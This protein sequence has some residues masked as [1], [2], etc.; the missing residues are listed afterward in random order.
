MRILKL[1]NILWNQNRHFA[2]H[3]KPL[4][5]QVSRFLPPIYSSNSV[6]PQDWPPCFAS[7]VFME[8]TMVTSDEIRTKVRICFLPSGFYEITPNAS[9]LRLGFE[10]SASLTRL[11]E[12]WHRVLNA[13]ATDSKKTLDY[14]CFKSSGAI[15]ESNELFMLVETTQ[16][17]HRTIEMWVA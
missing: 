4:N 1:S 14:Q 15:Y 5:N 17:R 11:Y 2:P 9:R 12:N 3:I 13:R 16:K 10:V 8:M 7:K 6:E